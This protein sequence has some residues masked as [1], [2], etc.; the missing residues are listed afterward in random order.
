M[1]KCMVTGYFSEFSNRF[2]EHSRHNKY[3]V[4]WVTLHCCFISLSRQHRSCIFRYVRRPAHTV[5]LARCRR[6]PAKYSGQHSPHSWAR[7]NTRSTN[8]MQSTSSA[9]AGDKNTSPMCVSG[10]SCA[11]LT[12]KTCLQICSATGLRPCGARE[13]VVRENICAGCTSV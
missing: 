11:K 5:R 6:R 13:T 12:R 7:L 9:S 4:R 10:D 2:K 3:L 1:L 8:I